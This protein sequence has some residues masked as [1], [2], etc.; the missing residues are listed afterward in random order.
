MVSE[1]VQ[2]P[3]LQTWFR[4]VFSAL[5]SRRSCSVRLYVLQWNYL[6]MVI[7]GLSVS[8]LGVVDLEVGVSWA[9]GP[10]WAKIEMEALREL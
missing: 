10:S 7:W 8:L 3:Y 2:Q 1:V 5:H 6:R 4:D 9:G